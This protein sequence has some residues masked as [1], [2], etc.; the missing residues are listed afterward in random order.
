MADRRDRVDAY[1]ARLAH[2][3]LTR[4][5]V[6]IYVCADAWICRR[7]I[8]RQLL[9]PHLRLLDCNRNPP[10]TGVEIKRTRELLCDAD[11]TK[12]WETRI[13][14]EP[15]SR[16]RRR[17]FRMSWTLRREFRRVFI[18]VMC[19]IFPCSEKVKSVQVFFISQS[20][21]TYMKPCR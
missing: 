16:W 14:P 5:Q 6:H 20:P 3:N 12:L 11:A 1:C 15:Y 21:T 4:W 10:A 18:S 13:A 2:C 9:R 8:E 7:D 17:I 19:R